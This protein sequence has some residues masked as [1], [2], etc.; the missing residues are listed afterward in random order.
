MKNQSKKTSIKSLEEKH[1]QISMTIALQSVRIRE[2]QKVL[3]D[4]CDEL[5]AVETEIEKLTLEE[6]GGGLN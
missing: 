3:N 2:M 6:S 1:Y 5:L 4:K